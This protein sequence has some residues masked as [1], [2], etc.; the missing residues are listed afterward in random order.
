MDCCFTMPPCSSE[1]MATQFGSTTVTRALRYNRGL[2][3][4]SPRQ[5]HQACSASMGIGF[6]PD[7]SDGLVT[8]SKKLITTDAEY[9][10][11]AKQMQLLGL[12]ND[13]Y[14]NQPQIDAVGR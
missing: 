8:P 2:R 4:A 9:G 11:T 13:S 1:R 12:T 5:Q 3:R 7:G 10:L 6:A 14:M